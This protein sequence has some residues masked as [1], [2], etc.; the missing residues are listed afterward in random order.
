MS[1]IDKNF[2]NHLPTDLIKFP[3]IEKYREMMNQQYWSY[4]RRT[5][6]YLREYEAGLQGIEYLLR[7]TDLFKNELTGEEVRANR[8]KLWSFY[9][10]LLD[11]LDRWE[12][13]LATVE[14]LRQN[15]E[16]QEFLSH[17]SPVLTPKGRKAYIAASDRRAWYH[18]V[19]ALWKKGDPGAEVWMVSYI[20]SRERLIQ[21]K[22][23]LQKAG[24]SV[25]RFRH[26]S[27]AELTD[28]EY[29]RRIEVLKFWFEFPKKWEEWAKSLFNKKK[30]EVNH[31]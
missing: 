30:N 3:T 4:S 12:D 27:P 24:K 1:F 13:Y 19:H 2:K 6:L 5:I 25:K 22:I 23:D 9:L 15:P 14:M 29:R 16:G 11:K 21:K 18:S 7:L 10:Q 8:H 20:T 31:D 28:E 26:K 17:S